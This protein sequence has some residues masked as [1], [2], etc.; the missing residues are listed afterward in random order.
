[1]D[2]DEILVP[3]RY[4]LSN[5]DLAFAGQLAPIKQYDCNSDDGDATTI[6]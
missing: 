3:R 6:N 2:A 1:M 4:N 5:T